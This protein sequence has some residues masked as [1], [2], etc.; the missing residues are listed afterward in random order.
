MSA[1]ESE[2][3]RRRRTQVRQVRPKK[4]KTKRQSLSR[5][6]YDGDHSIA[7]FT[8]RKCGILFA[9]LQSAEYPIM[10]AS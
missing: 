4:K 1:R 10:I 7:A 8:V 6:A 3:G 9:S 5:T 2:G